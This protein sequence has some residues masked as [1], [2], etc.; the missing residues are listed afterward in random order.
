MNSQL[1]RIENKI[2]RIDDKIEDLKESR[3]NLK[4]KLEGHTTQLALIWTL[5][6]LAIGGTFAAYYKL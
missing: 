4:G 3:G 2:D 6:I 5:L 1:S